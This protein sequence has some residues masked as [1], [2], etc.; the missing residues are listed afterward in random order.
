MKNTGVVRQ[1]DELGRIVIPKE[2]R[3]NLR[4]REGEP[5]EF[6]IENDSIVLKKYSTLESIEELA[7]KMVKSL[8]AIARKNAII[9]SNEKVIALA[10]DLP[11]NLIGKEISSKLVEEIQRGETKTFRNEGIEITDFFKLKNSSILKPIIVYGN[12]LGSILLVG[13]EISDVEKALVD[14]TASFLSKYIDM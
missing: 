5:L 3:R 12:I 7:E 4:I 6:F 10:G 1:V 11:S 9:T 14:Y 13:D 8:N 2:I